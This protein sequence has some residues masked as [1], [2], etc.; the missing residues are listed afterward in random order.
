MRKS[1]NCNLFSKVKFDIAI[2]LI[3]GDATETA[4][5]KKDKL[6]TRH[7]IPVVKQ[8]NGSVCKM[9]FNSTNK[10]ALTIECPDARPHN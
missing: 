6:I 10:Y 4:L 3:I 1:N 8:A 9:P 2:A 5:I 7:K